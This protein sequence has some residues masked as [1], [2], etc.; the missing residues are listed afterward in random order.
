MGNARVSIN[1]THLDID[2]VGGQVN[3]EYT[4]DAFFSYTEQVNRNTETM[5][6]DLEKNEDLN[7]RR[8]IDGT[9]LRIKYAKSGAKLIDKLRK[10]LTVKVPK[11]TD[12]SSLTVKAVSARIESELDAWRANFETVSG[13]INCMGTF[14]NNL[15]FETVSGDV[16]YSTQTLPSEIDADTVSGNV[17]FN[18][19]LS[20]SFTVAFESVSG[21][22]HTDS[23][24][25]GTHNGRFFTVN[26]G[27]SKIKTET[28]SGDCTL[29]SL[30]D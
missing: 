24:F 7:M 11:R 21:N 17:V 3:L 14:T 12:L 8:I 30:P 1:V 23:A 15:N 9:T 6:F 13:R 4:D 2:W 20:A 18:F 29:I 19:P 26:G 27:S 22:L 5:D 10:T 28:V 25:A 16:K